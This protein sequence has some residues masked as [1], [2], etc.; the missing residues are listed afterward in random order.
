MKITEAKLR[1]IIR[2]ELAQDEQLVDQHG[3]GPGQDPTDPRSIEA[4]A[5]GEGGGVEAARLGELAKQLEEGLTGRRH[6]D[7]WGGPVGTNRIGGPG[8]SGLG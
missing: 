4:C 6:G 2:E 3:L 1:Q 8:C 7:S 5:G